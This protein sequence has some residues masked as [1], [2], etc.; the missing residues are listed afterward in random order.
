M[1]GLIQSLKYNPWTECMDAME[2]TDDDEQNVSPNYVNLD[3]SENPLGS[4]RGM[5]T[6]M[7]ESLLESSSAGSRGH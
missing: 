6:Y 4:L 2:W 3:L 7:Y 5:E 1:Q